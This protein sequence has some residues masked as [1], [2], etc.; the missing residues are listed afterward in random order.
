MGLPPVGFWMSPQ[1]DCTVSLG[2]LFQRSATL[3]VKQI[4]WLHSYKIDVFV[5]VPVVFFHVSGHHCRD[6][7]PLPHCLP[8]SI[9]AHW[10][11]THANV[12]LN[13]LFSKMNNLNSLVSPYM[14]NALVPWSSLWP[15]AIFEKNH[16]TKAAKLFSEP[17]IKR[18]KGQMKTLCAQWKPDITS[19]FSHLS[20]VSSPGNWRRS[21]CCDFLSRLWL[22]ISL[23]SCRGAYNWMLPSPFLLTPL[24]VK[25]LEIWDPTDLQIIVHYYSPSS[26]EA[27]VKN[28][29]YAEVRE[30]VCSFTKC[31]SNPPV[32]LI[33]IWLSQFSSSD[34]QLLKPLVFVQAWCPF[35]SSRSFSTSRS[36]TVSLFK[37]Y[38]LRTDVHSWRSD[39]S[40]VFGFAKIH[41]PAEAQRSPRNGVGT[42][43]SLSK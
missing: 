4:I 18:K 14:K 36:P 29:H 9:Y 41:P 2:N 19:H 33:I 40:P 30:K 5:F 22:G 43:G 35:S 7:L 15:W 1:V 17:Q 24:S 34:A 11:W 12:P 16:L 21:L 38:F 42:Q 8:S 6:W 26:E 28:K 13:C 32:P 3:T 37:L 27:S 39:D 31:E 10:N 25:R 23:F 20:L